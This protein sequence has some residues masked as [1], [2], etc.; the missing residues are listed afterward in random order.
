MNDGELWQIKNS[1]TYSMDLGKEFLQRGVLKTFMTLVNNVLPFFFQEVN[2]SH[3]RMTKMKDLSAFSSL[4]KLDLGC[5][6]T[7]RHLHS[8]MCT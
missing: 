1:F 8:S 5:I 6:L 4:S 3:N 7:D 2:F